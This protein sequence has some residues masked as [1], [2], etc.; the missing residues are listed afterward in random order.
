MTQHE[1]EN[2]TNEDIG[3]GNSS[4]TH[5]FRCERCKSEIRTTYAVINTIKEL[6]NCDLVLIQ[7]IHDL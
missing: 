1:F 4:M 6:Q 3:I 2:I 7:L 5:T